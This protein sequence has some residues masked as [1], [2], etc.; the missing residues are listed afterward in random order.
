MANRQ[1]GIYKITNPNNKVYVGQ[2]WDIDKRFRKYKSLTSIKKQR[3]L[4]NSIKKYGI[5]AHNFEIVYLL[6]TDIEQCTLDTYEIFYISQFKEAGYEMMNIRE[7]GLGGKLPKESIEKMIKTRGK[8]NHSEETRKKI[9]QSHKGMKHSE[10][11][12][13][14]FRTLANAGKLVLNTET[15]IF[16]DSISLVAKVYNINQKTLHNRLVGVSKNKTS[17]TLI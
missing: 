13:E 9:S 12:K 5:E 10:E 16:Y 15:G 7:G 17:L 1:I 8:W 3:F 4:Y 6:P 2:S 14:R 11:T